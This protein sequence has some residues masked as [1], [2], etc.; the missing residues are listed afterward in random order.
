MT[1]DFNQAL[2]PL[3][4][5]YDVIANLNVKV[6]EDYYLPCNSQSLEVVDESGEGF[7]DYVYPDAAMMKQN[8]KREPLPFIFP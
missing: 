7:Q 4:A 2:L 8:W 6:G 1:C 3:P 5:G